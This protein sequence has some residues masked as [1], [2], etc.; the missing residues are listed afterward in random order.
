[1]LIAV[2]LERNGE[3]T[4]KRFL[5]VCESVRLGRIKPTAFR[6]GAGLTLKVGPSLG[7][8]NHDCLRTTATHCIR[9]SGAGFTQKRA[10]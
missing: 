2:I 5:R 4:K 7:T 8:R 9:D 10:K 3:K 6:L 1:M